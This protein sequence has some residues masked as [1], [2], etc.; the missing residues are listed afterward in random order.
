MIS[1]VSLGHTGRSLQVGPLMS[2][3]FVCISLAF[4]IRVFA[5]LL[6]DQYLQLIQVTALLW[7]LAYALFILVYLPILTTERLDGKPG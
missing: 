3:A 1:R 5:P 2:I 6:L 4:V 7:G